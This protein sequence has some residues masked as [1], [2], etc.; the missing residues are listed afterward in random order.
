MPK[1]D[2]SKMLSQSAARSTSLEI[3]RGRGVGLSVEQ[4]T[5]Q[6]A[7]EPQVL[8]VALDHILDNPYQ[9]VLSPTLFNTQE[10]E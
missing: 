9:H 5:T 1:H 8:W 2:L 7:Q 6:A 4:E 3:R 10:N